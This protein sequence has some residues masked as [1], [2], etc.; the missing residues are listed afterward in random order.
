MRALKPALIFLLVVLAYL[1]ALGAGFVWEDDKWFSAVAVLGSQDTLRA[2]WQD[3]FAFRET[4]LPLVHSSFW[5][6]YLFWGLHPLG[7]HLT[8]VLLHAANAVLFSL[9]LSQLALPGAWLAGAVFALHPVHVESVA[10]ITERKN[11]LSCLFYLLTALYF[12]RSTDRNKK[13]F[14]LLS[15]FFFL[16]AA[17]SKVAALALPLV[18]FLALWV[19]EGSLARKHLPALVPFFLI[20]VLRGASAVWI[21]GRA[22]PVEADLR[23][24]LAERLLIAGRAV[25]FY[26]GQLVWPR[27]LML[28]YPRWVVD[29]GS[30]LPFAFPL[31]AALA[32]VLLWA[33]RKRWG[34]GPLA[35]FLSLILV[36][37][38]TLGF[39]SIAYYRYSF[40]TDHW[41][42]HASLGPIAL[43]GALFAKFGARGRA[44]AG[45]VLVAFGIL[46]WQ[47]AA[48]YRDEETL[49]SS[50]V[51]KNP[52]AS[53]AQYNLGVALQARGKREE[54]LA[55]YEEALRLEPKWVEV[56]NNMGVILTEK[57]EWK[58]AIG[59]L[60]EAVR[61]KPDY[62]AAHSNLGIALAREGSLEE[63]IR[64]L[65]EAIRLDPQSLE[66]YLNLKTALEM[67]AK[68][69]A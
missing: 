47:Q 11:V 5:V 22:V 3:P 38:P 41:L 65:S 69:K 37:A 56:H 23:W 68:T 25:W 60:A 59:H 28:I 15:I 45:L 49:W 46:T 26:L 39:F 50:S 48:I 4:Y 67:R 55:H 13:D 53:I 30:S 24:S 64:H 35:A 36:L 18:M 7:Y 42:Y 29:S 43:T 31:G 8:N 1:P 54:A 61:M 9:V 62:A 21:E 58:G 20:G 32:A 63:A 10:W 33:F 19:K 12:F 34:R 57:E 66:G 27:N 52:G 2:I 51:Q 40:V 17:L 6:E 44:A 16:C 14:Y